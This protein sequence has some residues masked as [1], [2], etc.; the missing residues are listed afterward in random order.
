MTELIY[1][2]QLLAVSWVRKWKWTYRLHTNTFRKMIFLLLRFFGWIRSK[3]KIFAK[4]SLSF[5]DIR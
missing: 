5:L 3:D 1:R 2:K 4:V